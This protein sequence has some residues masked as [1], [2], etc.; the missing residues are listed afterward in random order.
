MDKK[1]F[2]LKYIILSKFILFP[3]AADLNPEFMF[4]IKALRWNCYIMWND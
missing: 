1:V 2:L 4:A 3:T